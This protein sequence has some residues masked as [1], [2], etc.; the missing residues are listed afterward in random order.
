LNVLF[1]V[2]VDLEGA[3]WAKE[4]HNQQARAPQPPDSNAK[5]GLPRHSGARPIDQSIDRFETRVLRPLK[6]SSKAALARHGR[7]RAAR[8]RPRIF[9]KSIGRSLLLAVLC[10]AIVVGRLSRLISASWR[11]GQHSRLLVVVESFKKAAFRAKKK[12]TKKCKKPNACVSVCGVC[13]DLAE[14]GKHEPS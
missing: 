9:S 11:L 1:C 12:T 10:A 6:K 3:A 7:N 4:T 2:C 14:G 13:V 5:G 8:A